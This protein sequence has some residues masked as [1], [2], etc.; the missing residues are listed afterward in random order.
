MIRILFAA[1]L[2]GLLAGCSF[3]LQDE[4]DQL[5]QDIRE[6]I[7]VQVDKETTIAYTRMALQQAGLSMQ[8]ISGTMT[9]ATFAPPQPSW[10][11][12]AESAKAACVV[13]SEPS[14]D[15]TKCVVTEDYGS[16]SGIAGKITRTFE[17]SFSG[18]KITVVFANYAEGATSDTDYFSFDGNSVLSG[19]VTPDSFTLSMSSNGVSG[20]NFE[21][22]LNEVDVSSTLTLG[23]SN[24]QLTLNGT[25]TG[26][27]KV[28]K[29]TATMS[30][31]NL[32]FEPTCTTGPVNGTITFRMGERDAISNFSACGQAGM[33][34]DGEEIDLNTEDLVAA[35]VRAEIRTD[36]DDEDWTE[37]PD[38]TDRDTSDPAD[39]GSGPIERQLIASVDEESTYPE[40]VG[41][42]Y[43]TV[44]DYADSFTIYSV[45]GDLQYIRRI[46]S[47]D[48]NDG[49][50]LGHQQREGDLILYTD[51][52]LE[53]YVVTV[54]GIDA[55]GVIID[56]P[57]YPNEVQGGDGFHFDEYGNFIL[58][59]ATFYPYGSGGG[60]EPS[61]PERQLIP[62]A[63]E[64]STYPDLVGVWH[65]DGGSD[66]TTLDFHAE[67]GNILFTSLTHY[68]DCEGMYVVSEWAEGDL[69]LYED[70]YM[71]VYV[72]EMAQANEEGT[73]TSA[74]ELIE[75]VVVSGP[76]DFDVDG[77][78][79]SFGATY[80]LDPSG[81]VG[82]AFDGG[83]CDEPAPAPEL[84][85][86]NMVVSSEEEA[87]YPTLVGTWY[88]DYGYAFR[89]LVIT[90]E[91]GD[92]GF[93]MTDVYGEESDESQGDLVFY[94]ETSG[95]YVQ[96]T[97]DG[98]DL[99]L[100]L[101]E[102]WLQFTEFNQTM[103]AGEWYTQDPSGIIE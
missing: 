35:F 88:R 15:N 76:F 91:G 75:D 6:Q 58:G 86:E 17:G 20:S 23:Y 98:G 39:G 4:L 36:Y 64:Q 90:S 31:D 87:T 54:Y 55:D 46:I 22:R 82:E 40:L 52:Y 101:E 56:G 24:A 1:A 34:I 72:T 63:D 5:G 12:L 73:L 26:T 60:T 3:N 62:S 94:T 33:T 59:V 97:V 14:C 69:L 48:P 68:Y 21:G 9:G 93:A 11:T 19:T 8:Q 45:G 89:T 92:L 50:Y 70:S 95:D 79:I 41:T 16:C 18:Y 2:A 78:L 65:R 66:F 44:N 57:Y 28:S 100:V 80:T 67:G 42:W 85:P 84:N 74:P 10:Q 27:F 51:S 13:V 81:D 71:E 49:S 102:G 32:I 61:L 43:R 99:T 77:N 30:L 96:M 25:Q 29:Q 47:Y 7:E 83:A 53:L 38:Y 37:E 103:I